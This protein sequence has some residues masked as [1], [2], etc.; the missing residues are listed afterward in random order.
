MRSGRSG[1]G[2]ASSCIFWVCLGC[3]LRCG[4]L[5]AGGGYKH[6]LH[7]LDGIQSGLKT[8]IGGQCLQNG[9]DP[10]RKREVNDTVMNWENLFF[11]SG[12]DL[13]LKNEV[14]ETMLK[15]NVRRI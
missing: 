4:F 9:L 5:G 10:I 15:T 8:K 2:S 6:R 3:G 1:G 14:I 12:S 7:I 11:Q 13:S